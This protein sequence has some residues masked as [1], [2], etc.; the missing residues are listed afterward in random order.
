MKTISHTCPACQT[1]IVN[2]TIL[3]G[4]VECPQCKRNFEPSKATLTKPAKR[5]FYKK[6]I[7]VE[8]LSETEFPDDINLANL[9][10]EATDG[11][12]SYAIVR[13]TDSKMTGKKAA[14][15]LLKQGSEPSFFHLNEDGT[16][17]NEYI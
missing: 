6:T 8:F 4:L 5:V 12:Y 13:E 10:F 17:I 14:R 9:V 2:P 15:E 7:M 1:E 3:G 16:D 11:D